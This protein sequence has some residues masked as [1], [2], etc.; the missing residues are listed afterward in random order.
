MLDSN[1]PIHHQQRVHH[2]SYYSSTPL[3]ERDSTINSLPSLNNY[4]ASTANISGNKINSSPMQQ[5]QHNHFNSR[6]ESSSTDSHHQ[7][8]QH[9]LY[10]SSHDTGH[11][12][13][14]RMHSGYYHHDVLAPPTSQIYLRGGEHYNSST[15]NSISNNNDI[16][17]SPMGHHMVNNPNRIQSINSTHHQHNSS[18]PQ[19]PLGIIS[20]S[21]AYSTAPVVS[22]PNQYSSYHDNATPQQPVI[23]VKV[24]GS[25]SNSI[26]NPQQPP[27]YHS[28][29]VPSYYQRYQQQHEEM[30]NTY[31]HSSTQHQH[32]QQHVPPS[33]APGMNNVE[34]GNQPP[35]PLKNPNV[36]TISKN[37]PSSKQLEHKSCIICG[38]AD[39]GKYRQNLCSNQCN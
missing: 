30:A 27:L 33:T 2:H 18:P 15:N 32:Y 13:L 28:R 29:P 16:C 6:H 7:H 17:V 12:H 36:T 39:T 3:Y 20:R 25:N 1:Q 5:Q 21:S 23:H 26:A 22:E 4:P 14:S 8:Q 38:K 9:H 19:S 24:T 31:P 35:P 37:Q 34:R 10:P 11:N